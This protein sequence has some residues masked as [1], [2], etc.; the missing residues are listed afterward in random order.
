MLARVATIRAQLAELTGAGEGP[1]A[2][3]AIGVTWPY[4]PEAL[5]VKPRGEHAATKWLRA[6]PALDLVPFSELR[7]ID[8][9]RAQGHDTEALVQ[10]ATAQR[11]RA[12]AAA[13]QNSPEP[14]PAPVSA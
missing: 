1:G 6:A 5:N 3:H 13:A 2:D 7:Q 4:Q 11:A 8:I 14:T 10:Q 9:M 12:K